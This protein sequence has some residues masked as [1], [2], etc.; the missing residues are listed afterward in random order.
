ME[1]GLLG[2][3]YCLPLKN[4]ILLSDQVVCT[5]ELLMATDFKFYKFCTFDCIEYASWKLEN[6]F[7]KRK[8]I[9]NCK[10]LKSQNQHRKT[11]SR[12]LVAAK[13]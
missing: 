8:K 12:V 7:K 4:L 5:N 3:W 13:V 10:R 6:T 1:N 2:R 11:S 9:E